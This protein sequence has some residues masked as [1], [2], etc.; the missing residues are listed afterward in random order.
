ME[1]FGGHQTKTYGEIKRQIKKRKHSVATKKK[2]KKFE[3]ILIY[4][5]KKKFIIKQKR[6][7]IFNNCP[8]ESM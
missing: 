2:W 4:L 6:N 5:S 7:G 1:K 3:N 8:G